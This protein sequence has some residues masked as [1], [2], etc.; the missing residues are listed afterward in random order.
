MKHVHVVIKW[1]A[2]AQEFDLSVVAVYADAAAAEKH[3]DLEIVAQKVC[4]EHERYRFAVRGPFA[5]HEDAT[6][7]ISQ[8]PYGS[9]LGKCDHCGYVIPVLGIPHSGGIL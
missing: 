4:P 8:L 9:G 7:K 2:N 5:V 1:R 6:P 3:R